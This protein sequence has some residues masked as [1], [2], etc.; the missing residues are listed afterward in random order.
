MTQSEILNQ[1]VEFR[2]SLVSEDDEILI[3]DILDA[4]DTKEAAI[5]GIRQEIS[6][7]WK[8][9]KQAASD[10]AKRACDALRMLAYDLGRPMYTDART[11]LIAVMEGREATD[12]QK[13]Q[14]LNLY[15]EWHRADLM[16]DMQLAGL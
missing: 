15:N 1:L 9:E 2:N 7:L 8:A 11:A 4:F 5:Y 10:T 6:L 14:A 16:S 12:N 3:F 13:I